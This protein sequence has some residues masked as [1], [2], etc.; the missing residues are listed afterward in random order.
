MNCNSVYHEAAARLEG[1]HIRMSINAITQV[2]R[3]FGLG[4]TPVMQAKQAIFM[5][6]K[7][8]LLIVGTRHL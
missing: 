1:A 2:Q 4:Q 8:F 6:M 7:V 5:N 3:E